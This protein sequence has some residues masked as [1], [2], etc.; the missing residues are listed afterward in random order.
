MDRHG[1]A[2][3]TPVSEPGTDTRPLLEMESGYL[4][5]AM[6][7]LPRQ[8]SD[9]PWI[10]H[11]KYALDRSVLRSAPVDDPALRFTECVLETTVTPVEVAAQ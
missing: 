3:V 1:Y 10:A 8:G 5:R 6:H 2:T 7:L 11:T 4:A 9:A